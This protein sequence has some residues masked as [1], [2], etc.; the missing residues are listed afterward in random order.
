M[1]FRIAL[2]AFVCLSAFN[3]PSLFA[4]EPKLLPPAQNYYLHLVQSASL[5]LGFRYGTF[6]WVDTPGDL[7][8]SEALTVETTTQ[9]RHSDDVELRLINLIFR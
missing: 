7:I 1:V 9:S 8:V 5:G 4:G 3:I 2:V 6:A